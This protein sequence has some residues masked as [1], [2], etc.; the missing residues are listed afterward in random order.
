VREVTLTI[1]SQVADDNG[2]S[3]SQS[4][5][6]AGNLTIT[7][8]LATA[9]VA[10]FPSPSYVSITSAADDSGITWTVTGTDADGAALSE[11]I[12]GAD[13]AAATTTHR[14][15]TVTQIHGSDATAGAV[16]AG[17]AD[18]A[19]S[20]PCP[21][22]YRLVPFNVGLFFV[23]TGTTSTFTVQYSG[24]DPWDSAY[25]DADAYNALA[26][27]LNHPFMAGMQANSSG[28]IAFAV[29]AVRLQSDQD[30]TDTGKLK[31]VQ[32]GH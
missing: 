18:F 31:I 12:A 22:D 3:V 13:T 20:A 10:T 7:G 6:A 15:L 11:T 4:L 21:L 2:V 14:F 30:G 5:V 27:W 8:V 28:N 32:S 23:D 9:G 29:R 24:D 19:W 25:A 17:S 16:I 26:T 1:I